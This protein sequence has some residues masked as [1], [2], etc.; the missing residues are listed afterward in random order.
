MGFMHHVSTQDLFVT[1]TG[2]PP[3]FG[4]LIR[5]TIS[6]DGVYHGCIRNDALWGRLRWQR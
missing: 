1:R 5:T 3:L 6:F 2:A 4:R